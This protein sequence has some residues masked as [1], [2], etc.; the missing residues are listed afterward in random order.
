MGGRGLPRLPALA[1]RAVRGRAR[2]LTGEPIDP[3]VRGRRL[4]LALPGHEPERAPA[5]VR[6]G[7]VREPGQEPPLLRQP[8]AGTQSGAAWAASLR[9]ERAGPH[10]LIGE[11]PARAAAPR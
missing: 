1:P 10:A 4:R 9:P 2:D 5:V 3:E 7:G 6:H 8:E 11:A